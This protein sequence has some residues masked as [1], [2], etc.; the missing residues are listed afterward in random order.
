MI[1]SLKQEKLRPVDRPKSVFLY[2]DSKV[3]HGQFT[4]LKSKLCLVAYVISNEKV[5]HM[6]INDRNCFKK[7]RSH[8][9]KRKKTIIS[10]EKGREDVF[11]YCPFLGRWPR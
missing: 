6:G 7:H 2:L 9:V 5:F 11:L 8:W 3:S 1:V 10:F 4:G